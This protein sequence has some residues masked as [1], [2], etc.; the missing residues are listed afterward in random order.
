M[1][2][3]INTLEWMWVGITGLFLLWMIVVAY[4]QQTRKH[5]ARLGQH[6]PNKKVSRVSAPVLYLHPLLCGSVGER[7]SRA[8]RD[9]HGNVLNTTTTE[10]A[11]DLNLTSPRG[12]I[13]KETLRAY[14][15]TRKVMNPFLAAV[16]KND[17]KVAVGNAS[18]EDVLLLKGLMI[19]C[20]WHMPNSSWGSEAKVHAFMAGAYPEITRLDE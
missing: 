10:I 17:L 13:Y 2:E 7:E 1:Q 9:V 19:F 3:K 14:V 16:L 4:R 8:P 11:L 18:C 12:A 15:Q 6:P 20:H 5:L